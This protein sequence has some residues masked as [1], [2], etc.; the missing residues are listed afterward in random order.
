M[1]APSA[2]LTDVQRDRAIGVLLATA[3]GDAL[4]PFAPG[5]W[6]DGT[7]MAIAIA[8]IAATGTLLRTE[9]AQDYIV[10]R[11]HGWSRTAEDVGNQ[12]SW[13]LWSA[14][15]NGISARSARTAAAEH[16]QRTGRSAGS[17]S[18]VRTAP[19]ALAFLHDE[20][21]LVRSAREISGL[22]HFDPDAADAC[23]LWCTAIRHA[24]LT[25]ELDGRIGLEHLDAESRATWTARLDVAENS[26]PS[27]FEQN[28][29]VVAA[30]QGAWSAISTTDAPDDDP[31]AGVFG[32]DHLRLALEAAVRGGGDTGTG[33]A[34]AGG[35]LGA[36][37]GASAV[38]WLWRRVLKGWPG[39]N[40]R[41]LV[42]LANRIIDRG[43]AEPTELGYRA[44]TGF[45]LP[46]PH[47]ADE[48]LLLGA[49][50]SLRRLPAGVDAVASLCPVADA[51]L[52]AGVEHLDVRL[53]D[54]AAGNANLDFVLLDTVRAI[55]GLRAEGATV[56][57]HGTGVTSRVA[58]VAAL[59][60]ARRQ[61]LG[62]AEALAQIRAVIPDADPNPDF[63]AALQRLAPA[64]GG[65][66]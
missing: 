48:H 46:Q 33:A 45:P 57:V 40:A 22:T 39:L 62:W 56:F 31:A 10:Q 4:G 15:R 5:E 25:G 21:F 59:Y 34:I 63:K 14:A 28:G 27:D 35:L 1:T 16:H 47:P 11:W 17:G 64:V 20:D 41:G 49:A 61:G 18:L 60:A 37:Y 58:A 66:R 12:T 6:A 42:R 50:P 19:V 43:D 26:A 32:C 3:A 55:E 52:P 36:V 8:E 29:W 53:I 51:D 7:A 30:L 65:A 38:P 2:T 44:T 54:R 24:V 9:R 13:V 23:V